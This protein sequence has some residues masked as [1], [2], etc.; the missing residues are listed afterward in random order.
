MRLLEYTEDDFITSSDV[1]KANKKILGYQAYEDNMSGALEWSKKGDDE[2]LYATPSWDGDWGITPFDDTLENHYGK[3][4]F[5]KSKY[6][7]NKP[8]Q[9][10]LYFQAVKIALEKFEKKKQK[11]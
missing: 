2:A 3:L 9:L 11:K 1:L 6:V 4:D 8:L 7:G 5:S 10:K